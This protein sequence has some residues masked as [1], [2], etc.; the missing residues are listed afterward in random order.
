MRYP[1]SGWA[2]LGASSL[3][4]VCVA[5][6]TSV[7][8]LSFEELVDRSESIVSGHVTRSWAAWDAEHK[9]IW[10]HYEVAVSAIHKGTPGAT[11]VVSEAGGTLDGRV[12]TIAGTVTYQAGENVLVFLTRVPNGYLRTTGWGQGKYTVDSKGVLHGGA[13]LRAG[14]SIASLEGMSTA[15][16]HALV[17]ARPWVTR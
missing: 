11:V 6:A 3:L 17:A 2:R 14:T 10:T 9:F 15:H 7:I 1:S 4:L 5:G 12:M 13:S 8:Q 16:L